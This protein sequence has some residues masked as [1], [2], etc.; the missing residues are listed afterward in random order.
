MQSI[1]PPV[2]RE[3]QLPDPWIASYKFPTQG[4][5][6][7]MSTKS[8]DNAKLVMAGIMLTAGLVTLVNAIPVIILL[9]GALIAWRQDDPGTIQTTTKVVRTLYLVIALGMLAG[10]IFNLPNAIGSEIENEYGGYNY[11][12]EVAQENIFGLTLG[13]LAALTIRFL[14]SWLWSKPLIRYLEEREVEE[15]GEDGPAIMKRDSLASYSVADELKKW[16]DLKNDGTITEEEFHAAR[17]RIL[18]GH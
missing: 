2:Q 3:E 4:E 17:N 18:G 1:M 12:H 14:V 10:V 13:F 6:V 8:N 5:K 11:R 9:A 16:R 7:V 15:E